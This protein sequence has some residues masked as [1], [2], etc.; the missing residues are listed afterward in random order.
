[1]TDPKIDMRAAATLYCTPYAGLPNAPALGS[2]P[3][4]LPWC[5]RTG[6]QPTLHVAPPLLFAR[7]ASCSAFL[8]SRVRTFATKVLE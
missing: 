1:M 8:A 3:Y 6:Q 2:W 5:V 7:G 4:L